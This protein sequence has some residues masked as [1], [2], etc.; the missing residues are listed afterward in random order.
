MERGYS[1]TPFIYEQIFLYTYHIYHK[2]CKPYCCFSCTPYPFAWLVLEIYGYLVCY[3]LMAFVYYIS[4][5]NTPKPLWDKCPIWMSRIVLIVCY[6][7]WFVL[8]ILWRPFYFKYCWRVNSPAYIQCLGFVAS[9]VIYISIFKYQFWLISLNNSMPSNRAF[10]CQAA[11]RPTLAV[12]AKWRR[13]ESVSTA[14]RRWLQQ[15]CP[16]CSSAPLSWLLLF[17]KPFQVP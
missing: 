16:P 13:A 2:T 10:K 6:L 9:L 8:D 11:E 5:P 17:L 12:P 15:H 1:Q 14:G 4:V 3:L 7:L